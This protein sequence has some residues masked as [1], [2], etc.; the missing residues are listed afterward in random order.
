MNLSIERIGW[1]LLLALT[2]LFLVFGCTGCDNSGM[3]GGVT[4]KDC[5]EKRP[6][7]EKR[8]PPPPR[9]PAPLG[10]GDRVSVTVGN[11]AVTHIASGVALG[12]PSITGYVE[13]LFIDNVG[14]P[15]KMVLPVSILARE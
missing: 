2:L 10:V 13:V 8:P 3:A 4:P 6:D 11:W 15:T 5:V 9:E 12:S 1:A 14:T 7:L